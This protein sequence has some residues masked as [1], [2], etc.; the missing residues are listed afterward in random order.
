MPRT[1]VAERSAEL[2]VGY[3]DDLMRRG[4]LAVQ[5][6]GM[7]VGNDEQGGFCVCGMAEVEHIALIAQGQQ[8]GH[9]KAA[10]AAIGHKHDG[11]CA[12]ALQVL[13]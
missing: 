6:L 8:V 5:Q 11:V 1:A 9:R 2:I 13:R 7:V 4:C 12:L 10:D 3:E